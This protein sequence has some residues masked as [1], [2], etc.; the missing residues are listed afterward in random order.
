MLTTDDHRRD[1]AGLRYV[2]PVVSRRAGGVSIGINLNVNNAC[3]WACVYCQVDNLVRGGPPPLDLDLLESELATFLADALHGDFMQRQVPESARRLMDIAFSGN[4]EPTSAPE[5][6]AAVNR[7]GD[8][9]GRFGL[10]GKLVLRLITNGSL[11]H[12]PEVAAGVQRIGEL[13]GE[14]WFK[15]DRA[16]AA[17]IAEINGVPLTPEKVAGNL[18]RCAALAPTWVQTC[19]FAL[20]GQAPDAAARAAYCDLLTPVAG[21]LA[22]VHLYGLARPS[23]QPA[24]PRLARLPD[25]ELAA[26][27]EEIQK[28]TGIRVLISP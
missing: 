24:A 18:A 27:A 6:A 10:L 11:M 28:K 13:G 3:N 20:D 7:V 25:E 12:R 23:Q 9:L 5:F 2:Y 14:V 19:W 1:S 8:V 16:E 21:S 22:G 4:G 26:F 15:I 17:A